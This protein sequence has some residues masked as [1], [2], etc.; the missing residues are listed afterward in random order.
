MREENC[1]LVP[2]SVAR[3]FA[4]WGVVQH[5]ESHEFGLLQTDVYI[6]LFLVLSGSFSQTSA[7]CSRLCT[8]FFLPF[9]FRKGGYNLG[10]AAEPNGTR[11]LDPVDSE[12][13]SFK[14]QLGVP[15]TV[16]P[17]YLLCSL[18]ILGDYGYIQL[19][20]VHV[21]QVFILLAK[22]SSPSNLPQNC[23]GCELCRS[24]VW[25]LSV[26]RLKG[27]I[28]IVNHLWKWLSFDSYWINIASS[29]SILGNSFQHPYLVDPVKDIDM[30]ER[31]PSDCNCDRSLSEST[32]KSLENVVV[33]IYSIYLELLT[34]I[35]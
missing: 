14:G 17:W 18:G 13:A 28:L 26:T 6:F 1:M 21:S 22:V 27:L 15:L 19:S 33:G 34:T 24:W 29:T 31:P 3:Q 30:F 2:S 20:L 32:P 10:P 5:F 9:F 11:C 7:W 35:F 23:L 8:M 16:Y 4:R 25:E 12:S